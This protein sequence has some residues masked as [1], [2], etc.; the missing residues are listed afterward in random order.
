M[1]IRRAPA[2]PTTE[3]DLDA[4]TDA[5]INKGLQQAAD[6]EPANTAK[7]KNVLLTIPGGIAR[8][9]DAALKHR[10]VRTPR[11]T[12]ILEAIVEKLEREL[13]VTPQ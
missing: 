9:I 11:H 8:N 3:T 6:S 12:W 2:A 7:P 5:F 4:R 13:P 1:T 10:K